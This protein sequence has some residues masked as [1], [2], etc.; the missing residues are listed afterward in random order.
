MK[1]RERD[2]D[3]SNSLN[4]FV[5]CRNN[6][7]DYSMESRLHFRIHAALDSLKVTPASTP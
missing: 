1:G 7:K 2:L 6:Y 4:Y 5:L 3:F